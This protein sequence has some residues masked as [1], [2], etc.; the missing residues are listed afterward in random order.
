LSEVRVHREHLGSLGS[1]KTTKIGKSCGKNREVR[2]DPRSLMTAARRLPNQAGK[3]RRRE[4]TGTVRTTCIYGA[5]DR[6][7]RQNDTKRSG[8]FPSNNSMKSG[9]SN[10]PVKS[11]AHTASRLRLH[12]SAT[13][14]TRFTRSD[15]EAAPTVPIP[16][17]SLSPARAQRAVRTA[18]GTRGARGPSRGGDLALGE[19]LRLG[20]AFRVQPPAGRTHSASSETA[21]ALVWAARY[22]ATN[23]LASWADSSSREPASA[24]GRVVGAVSR[25][26]PAAAL[27]SGACWDKGRCCW[28]EERRWSGSGE[29]SNPQRGKV[30]KRNVSWV[31]EII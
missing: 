4:W 23:A 28:E 25:Y 26:L 8:S 13:W 19:P 16:R 15:K 31:V 29:V 2:H 6:P 1:C 20:F 11:G 5:L 10:P 9:A 14:W 12:S 18:G 27:Y 3:K 17:E 24:G 22:R 7:P 30:P 21:A